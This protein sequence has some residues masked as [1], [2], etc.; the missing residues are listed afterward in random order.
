MIGQYKIALMNKRGLWICAARICTNN[1]LLYSMPVLFRLS[2]LS[3][4]GFLPICTKN[5][6]IKDKSMNLMAPCRKLDIWKNMQIKCYSLDNKRSKWMSNSEVDDLG[7]GERVIVSL[8]SSRTGPIGQRCVENP[9]SRPSVWVEQEVG[10]FPSTIAMNVAI[11]SGDIGRIRSNIWMT[12]SYYLQAEN[13]TDMNGLF[14]RIQA[15][16]TT[17]TQLTIQ[18]PCPPV[19]WEGMSSTARMLVSEFVK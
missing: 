5:G 14:H 18:R 8:I 16:T 9:W 12:V 10:P 6:E 3:F 2:L 4:I 11:C 13:H 17:T 1:R 19:A 15:T 7:V